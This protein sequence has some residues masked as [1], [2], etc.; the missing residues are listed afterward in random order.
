[1][2]SATAVRRCNHGAADRE[3]IGVSNRAVSAAPKPPADQAG[4]RVGN[5]TTTSTWTPEQ[6]AQ[7]YPLDVT[8]YGGGKDFATDRAHAEALGDEQ[9][10][11]T[12]PHKIFDYIGKQ[13]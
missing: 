9:F 3:W 6:V 4:V 8:T 7:T 2:Q 11:T 5:G 13:V 10:D 12:L 1:L